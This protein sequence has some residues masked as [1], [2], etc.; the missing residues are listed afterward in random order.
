[1]GA[2]HLFTP[3]ILA[4]F[5]CGAGFDYQPRSGKLLFHT[6]RSSQSLA[7]QKATRSPYSHMGL[8]FLEHGTAWVSEAVQPVQKT[9]LAQWIARGRDGAFVARRLKQGQR[10]LTPESVRRLKKETEKYLGRE[11]DLYFE[12]SDERVVCSEL[13]W[14][15][16]Q[17]ALGISLGAR[18]RLRSFDLSDPVVQAEIRERWPAGAPADEWVISPAAMFASEQ[19]ET[20]FIR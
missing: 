12:W 6:S 1:M 10:L 2:V 14:K 18:A 5:S 4:L 7:I 3:L 8:V 13:V 20:V 17:K 19:L 15:I 11:Y 16:Y 9:P